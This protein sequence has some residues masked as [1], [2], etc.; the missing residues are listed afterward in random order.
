MG[1]RQHETKIVYGNDCLDGWPAGKTPKY[2][3]ARY[4]QLVK[5]P[6]EPPH[7]Y[8]QPPNDRVFRLTQDSIAPCAY[9][10][11]SADWYIEWYFDLPNQWTWLTL[12]QFN[13]SA[14]HFL[15]HP[16]I[17]P[18]EGHV[19]HNVNP[20]CVPGIAAAGGIA[21]VT[22]R[23]ETLALLKALNIVTAYDLFMEMRPLADDKKVYKYCKLKDGTNVKILLE[24]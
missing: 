3:Y 18:T 11:Q 6:D 14:Q 1:Q 2:V 19:Y 10:Y 21:T 22:W 12:R 15:D 9:L 23:L 8:A 24:P 4:S 20:E 13:P 17:L 5:C 16:V 7:T